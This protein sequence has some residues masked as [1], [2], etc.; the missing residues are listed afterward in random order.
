M[1]D[2]EMY[3]LVLVSQPEES[4]VADETSRTSLSTEKQS[5]N[6]QLK[7]RIPE[8][9]IFTLNLQTPCLSTLHSNEKSPFVSQ[10][11]CQKGL[12][13]LLARCV[14]WGKEPF[15]TEIISSYK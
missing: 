1:C 2:A 7:A 5:Q 6:Q 11:L 4:K 8:M 10:S 15:Q 14:P 12:L 9:L 3:L 13:D